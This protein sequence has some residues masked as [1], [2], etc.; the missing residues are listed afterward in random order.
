M[1]KL[2]CFRVCEVDIG[3]KKITLKSFIIRL[4]YFEG[5]KMC[6]HFGVMYQFFQK[7]LR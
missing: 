1:A 4:L 5:E 6:G 2:T 3:I 7:V